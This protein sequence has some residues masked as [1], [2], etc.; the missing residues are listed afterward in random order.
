MLKEVKRGQIDAAIFSFCS[1]KNQ[2]TLSYFN[3]LDFLEW[4]AHADTLL[5]Y[6]TISKNEIQMWQKSFSTFKII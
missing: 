1:T 4:V 6:Q 3:Y 2:F 5:Y